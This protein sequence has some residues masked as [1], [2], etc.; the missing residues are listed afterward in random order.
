M[1]DEC[2][3]MFFDLNKIQ[4][5]VRRFRAYV[6][7]ETIK[8]IEKTNTTV[9]DASSAVMAFPKYLTFDLTISF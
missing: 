8:G 1:F 6:I 4:E 7:A 2:L 5:D 3:T 9:A